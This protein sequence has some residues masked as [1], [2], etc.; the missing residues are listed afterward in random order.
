M[1]IK[2][3]ICDVCK[4][5]VA[6]FRCDFCEKE[7]CNDD[8]RYNFFEFNI[9]FNGDT[10][11]KIE[12]GDLKDEKAIPYPILCKSCLGKLQGLFNIHGLNNEEIVKKVEYANKL[13][14]KIFEIIK[15]DL[16]IE[17]L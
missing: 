10:T 17:E 16:V 14:K 4:Y 12:N 11:L 8:G 1:E 5:R 2:T 7:L 9:K 13:S 3:N 6:K 15:K